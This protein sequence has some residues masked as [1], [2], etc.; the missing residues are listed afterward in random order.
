MLRKSLLL[1]AFCKANIT[2]FYCLDVSF[3]A[4]DT[5][6]HCICLQESG[7]KPIGC[8]QDQ[9][10]LSCGYYQIKLPYY[11]DCG[12]VGRQN[13]EDLTH[14]WQ[15]CSDDYNCATQCVQVIYL[16][17]RYRYKF[18]T[19]TIVIREIAP[20]QEKD[21]AKLWLVITTEDLLVVPTVAHLDTG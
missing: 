20:L 11:Q 10:S 1:L 5:C 9:G 16:M 4:A 18:R 3:G 19:T 12:E 21:S 2:I 8:E 7:C 15:R 17:A 13:G 14:A 6:L